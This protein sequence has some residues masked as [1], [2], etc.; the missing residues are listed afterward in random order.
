MRKS[1]PI[2][3]ALAFLGATSQ[4][5]L[6][7]AATKDPHHV[8][9]TNKK[10]KAKCCNKGTKEKAEKCADRMRSKGVADVQVMNGKC[11]SM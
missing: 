11:S 5:L 4:P 1:L 3:L 8:M 6:A 2:L 10:G 9:W 7:N